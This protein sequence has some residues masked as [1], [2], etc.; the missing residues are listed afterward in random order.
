VSAICEKKIFILSSRSGLLAYW[1]IERMV[2]TK[3]NGDE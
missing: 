1:V 2:E 3:N